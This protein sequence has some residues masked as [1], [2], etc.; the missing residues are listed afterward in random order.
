MTWNEGAIEWREYVSWSSSTH[1]HVR[2]LG[3]RMV[4]VSPDTFRMVHCHHTVLRGADY[5]N[6]TSN[7]WAIVLDYSKGEQWQPNLAAGAQQTTATDESD[8]YR[9]SAEWLR[10]LH[11]CRGKELG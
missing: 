4:T 8:G 7:V 2:I 3:Y 11:S 1:L 6:A 9:T 5:G 10:D